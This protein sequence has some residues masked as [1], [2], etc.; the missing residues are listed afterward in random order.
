ME[1]TRANIKSNLDY[2]VDKDGNLYN[3]H[4]E[5]IKG[6]YIEKYDLHVLGYKTESGNKTKIPLT[7]LVYQTFYPHIDIK[8]YTI[9]RLKL[10]VRNPYSLYNLQRIS[11]KE[12]PKENKIDLVQPTYRKPSFFENFNHGEMQNLIRRLKNKN[13]TLGDLAKLYGV[14]DMAIHRAKKKLL[15]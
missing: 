8:G 11:N 9:K 14:S 6:G 13:N 5:K 7:R 3:Q 1:L 4:K 12:M 10:N 2:Y 15:T